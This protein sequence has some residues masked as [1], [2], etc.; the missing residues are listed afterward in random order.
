MRIVGLDIL[1]SFAILF[2]LARHGQL[3]HNPLYDFGWLGVDLFF[4]LS[5]FLVSGLLFHEYKKK[6]SLNIKRFLIRRGFKIYPPFYIFLAFSILLNYWQ[7]G[8]IFP[9]KDIL[10]ELLYLQS[11]FS[12]IWAHTW[13]LA[14]EE[15]FYLGLALLSYIAYKTK[16]LTKK[17]LVVGT[18]IF[19]LVASFF[20][21]VYVSYPHRMEPFFAFMQTHLRSDGILFG[22]LASYL[23]HFTGF[24]QKFQKR[25]WLWLILGIALTIPGFVSHGGSYFMNTWGLTSVNF[26]FGIITLCSL[27]SVEIPLDI[28]KKIS[29]PIIA[30]LTLIG[31]HS[32][33]IY[34]WHILFR[35]L[36][37]DHIHFHPFYNTY[38]FVAMSLT[39]GI[40]LSYLIEKPFLKLRERIA[41]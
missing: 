26:G 22:V 29:R 13:S 31:K 8:N 11:Y 30:L 32:Y 2:V 10:V 18:L 15:H 39:G 40:L 25:N 20:M 34:L 1:R 33:S 19:M 4:A 35:N 21:R 5:G 3:V 37:N 36:V 28:L 7:T 14:V 9:F 24:Y 27:K 41:R 23:Y 38:I 6:G 17:Q 12:H 16:A